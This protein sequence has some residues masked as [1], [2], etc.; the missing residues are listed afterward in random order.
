MSSLLIATLLLAA[1]PEADSDAIKKP[2]EM[3]NAISAALV[4]EATAKTPSSRVVAVR[5]LSQLYREVLRD[6]LLAQDERLR[7]KAKLWA[8]LTKI[9]KE[10][11]RKQAYARRNARSS[12]VKS[13]AAQLE[14]NANDQIAALISSQFALA[15]RAIGG[16]TAVVGQASGA[17]GGMSRQDYGE[18]LVELI[19][20][21]IAPDTWD[22]N[23]GP[24]SIRYFANLQVLVVRQMG[25]VHGEV[26]P[27][28]D[29]LRRAGP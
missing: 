14:D 10:I 27:L 2:H 21:T 12:R 18:E 19:Q 9:K 28:L 23:G 24:G 29:G 8:R 26:A 22:V 11:E 25:N 3:R 15:G 16:P 5:E 20:S 13:D 7:L 4:A 6:T 17:Y 1:A